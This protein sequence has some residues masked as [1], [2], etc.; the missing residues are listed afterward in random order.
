MTAIETSRPAVDVAPPPESAT[1]II[2][3]PVGLPL[4]NANR[5]R[6]EHWAV[7][8]RTAKDIR[9]AAF[10]AARELR[11][12][13]IERARIVYVIHPSPQTRKRDPGNWAESAKAGVDG[14]VDAGVFPDDNSNHVIGPDPRIGEPVKGGQLVFHVT[15]LG[16]AE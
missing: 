4:L 6:R 3:L 2:P 9:T 11:I 15:P 14:L 8:R 7:V 5:S 10:V 1:Y 12:P 16:G 13:L